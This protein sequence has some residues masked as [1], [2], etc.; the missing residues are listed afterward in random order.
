MGGAGLSV[1]SGST[2]RMLKKDKRRRRARRR[3]DGNSVVDSGGSL[4]VGSGIGLRKSKVERTMKGSAKQ[5]LD[6]IV[7]R[8]DFTKIDAVKMQGAGKGAGRKGKK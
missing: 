2:S 3:K 8:I 6:H 1:M 5:I 7:S 4:F